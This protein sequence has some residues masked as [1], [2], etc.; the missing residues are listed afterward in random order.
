MEKIWIAGIIAFTLVIGIIAYSN[1]QLMQNNVQFAK[2]GLEQCP[3]Y[4]AASVRPQTIWVKDCSEYLK[5]IRKD[6]G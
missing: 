3:Q 4:G 2:Q 1:N 6:E 5:T